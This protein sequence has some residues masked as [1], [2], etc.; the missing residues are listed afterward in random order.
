MASQQMPIFNIV[1]KCI[2]N[3]IYKSQTAQKTTLSIFT[4]KCTDQS[5]ILPMASWNAAFLMIDNNDDGV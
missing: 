4:H 3:V 5:E 2:E 1:L